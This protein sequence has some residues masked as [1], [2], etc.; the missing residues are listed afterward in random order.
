MKKH[1]EPNGIFNCSV[2]AELLKMNSTNYTNTFTK[3]EKFT[4]ILC[5]T[6]NWIR[7]YL[8]KLSKSSVILYKCRTLCLHHQKIFFHIEWSWY[9]FP[10]LKNFPFFSL[11]VE[12]VFIKLISIF[13]QEF[14]LRYIGFDAWSLL[15]II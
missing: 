4:Y 8:F 9:F 2:A 6:T 11:K 5:K 3:M 14:S 1:Q 10:G 15:S 7:L 12:Y 13:F